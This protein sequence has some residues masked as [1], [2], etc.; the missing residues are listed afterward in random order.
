MS[1][2][3]LAVLQ[4]LNLSCH[5][6]RDSHGASRLSVFFTNAYAVWLMFTP[7]HQSPSDLTPYFHTALYIICAHSQ[8]G[9]EGRL[10]SK[11]LTDTYSFGRTLL[12]LWMKHLSVL[13]PETC[14]P[15]RLPMCRS[16]PTKLTPGKSN[17]KRE[18]LKTC[19]NLLTGIH[20]TPHSGL[21]KSE[22]ST[23][24]AINKFSKELKASIFSWKC[25]HV[26]PD[27][28]EEE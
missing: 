3:S 25:L 27:T 28:S 9:G 8:P 24:N 15:P 7:F 11:G 6:F 19:R 10:I 5:T 4:L 12:V 23:W 20:C 18:K 17:K 16:L 1:L 26:L 2:F 14:D 22:L 21:V 13:L